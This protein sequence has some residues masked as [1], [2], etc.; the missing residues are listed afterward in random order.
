MQSEAF[1][2][3]VFQKQG[4]LVTFFRGFVLPRNLI[5]KSRRKRVFQVDLA[6]HLF[7]VGIYG[8]NLPFL[9]ILS[10]AVQLI[11]HCLLIFKHL[12]WRVVI[13]YYSIMRMLIRKHQQNT[14][15]N[16]C[17]QH[18][19]N[20]KAGGCKNLPPLRTHIN[21]H[22]NAKFNGLAKNVQSS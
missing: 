8:N 5:G 10:Q 9:N 16:M 22:R 15:Q 11:W 6:E 17:F 21:V 1:S 20:N 4:K 12:V 19:Q 18:L 7:S 13:I 14:A 3:P 2:E